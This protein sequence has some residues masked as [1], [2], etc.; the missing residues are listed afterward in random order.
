MN[1]KVYPCNC[2]IKCLLISYDCKQ[3]PLG[4]LNA[5]KTVEVVLNNLLKIGF[6][7]S[8]L[9]NFVLLHTRGQTLHWCCAYCVGDVGHYWARWVCFEAGQPWG[10]GSHE[11]SGGRCQVA[12]VGG[13]FSRTAVQCRRGRNSTAQ[14]I[15]A[16]C[17]AAAVQHY[18][19]CTV[20]YS[21]GRY[22][23]SQYITIHCSRVWYC[24]VQC[25]AGALLKVH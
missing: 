3:I 11:S 14:H 5:K 15:A 1:W 13:G 10:Q 12:E 22:N 25:S 8:L 19:I 18:A 21:T 9:L 23:S 17:C 24:M 4:F 6:P 2:G 16:M 7:A 20:V